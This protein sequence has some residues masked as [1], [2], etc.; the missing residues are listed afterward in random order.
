MAADG[1][2]HPHV[3]VARRLGLI[4]ETANATPCTEEVT[5]VFACCRHNRP[6][7]LSSILE[8]DFPINVRCR[9]RHV[10]VSLFFAEFTVHIHASCPSLCMCVCYAHG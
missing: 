10:T 8:G 2:V 1:D 5:E 6:K 9:A 3:T 7:T 4:A